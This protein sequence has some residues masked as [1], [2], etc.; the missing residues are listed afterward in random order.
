MLNSFMK[1]AVHFF[2][3]FSLVGFVGCFSGPTYP[4][5]RLAKSVEELCLKEYNTIVQAKVQGKT[6]GV[7]LPLKQLL[8]SLY[9]EVS[10]EEK[11]QKAIDD[12]MHTI[13]RVTLS[14]DADIDFFTIVGADKSLG[15]ELVTTRY[16]E[17]LHRVILLNISLNDFLT[18]V[19]YQMGP[20]STI[21]GEKRIELFFRSLSKSGIEK[22][23]QQ[24]FVD[25][26]SLESISPTVFINMLEAGMKENSKYKILTQ[27]IKPINSTQMLYYIEAQET[28]NLKEEFTEDSLS[29][30]SDFVYKYL[31]LISTSN[32]SALIEKIY[33]LVTVN[34]EKQIVPLE[35]PEEFTEYG[36]PLSWPTEDFFIED[37]RLP[38]FIA[39]Q[40]AQNIRSILNE[41]N[42]KSEE[43]ASLVENVQASFIEEETV[44]SRNSMPK[45]SVFELIFTLKDS[46][47]A[48]EG[49]K[50]PKELLQTS[51][52]ALEQLCKNYSFSDYNSIRVLDSQKTEILNIDKSMIPSLLGK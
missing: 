49:K 31:I 32:Y 13:R 19:M 52:K 29:V 12:V 44:L 8:G 4:K 41:E 20:S 23:I 22:V 51:L 30:P 45:R 34:K 50:L 40:A 36:D 1:K 35:I 5:E 2:V 6:L 21:L 43:L 47:A 10:F 24:N 18:R 33:P 37:I 38:N 46:A 27:K 39:F 28:F 16:V 48:K 15:I 17:D 9:G 11:A 26:I 3:L 7:Y 25:N 14:T 42:E